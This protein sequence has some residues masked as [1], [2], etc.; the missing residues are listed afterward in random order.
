M[1]PISEPMIV[2]ENPVIVRAYAALPGAGAWDAT[3]LIINTVGIRYA[4]LYI[5]YLRGAVGGAADFYIETSPFTADLVAPLPSW[6]WGTIY[7]GGAV[8][9]NVDT[10]SRIQRE[11]LTYGATGAV[12]ENVAFGVVDL[13]LSTQR[14]R[15]T[16]RESGAV[17][18]PGNFGVTAIMMRGA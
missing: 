7:A 12:L 15:L 1:F 18:S 14:M 13:G 5:S 10:Q 6:F 17:G 8:A 9:A 4:A 3:P 2:V 16:A 11:Y